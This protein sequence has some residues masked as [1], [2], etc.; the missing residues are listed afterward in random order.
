MLRLMYSDG[1]LCRAFKVLRFMQSDSGPYRAYRVLTFMNS[2]GGL[3]RS[4]GNVCY[5]SQL[6]SDFCLQY[7]YYDPPTVFCDFKELASG[8][9]L[10]G[11]MCQRMKTGK[12]CQISLTH[13][14]KC[15]NKMTESSDGI[16]FASQQSSLEFITYKRIKILWQ[17]IQPARGPGPNNHKHSRTKHSRIIENEN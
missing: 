10:G 7:C 5:F 13:S 1:G 3:Y 4:K 16:H 11:R 8:R 17:R 15:E 6:V 9:G 2:D 14:T 12:I